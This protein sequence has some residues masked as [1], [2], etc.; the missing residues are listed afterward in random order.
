MS[1]ALGYVWMFLRCFVGKAPT[2]R[3]ALHLRRCGYLRP[4]GHNSPTWLFFG[5][6]YL[7]AMIV[8]MG[9]EL[10][11]AHL[12][13]GYWSQLSIGEKIA[14]LFWINGHLNRYAAMYLI[15][16]LILLL[17]ASSN[18]ARGRRMFCRLH[19]RVPS[20]RPEPWVRTLDSPPR[21]TVIT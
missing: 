18:L 5:H 16:A 11:I 3:D 10:S 14:L 6:A 2:H 13:V 8:V 4:L 17:G 15:W 12:K 19:Y 7:F 1:S 21:R 9:I 20:A